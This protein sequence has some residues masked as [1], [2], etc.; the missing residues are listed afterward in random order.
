MKSKMKTILNILT[1]CA[2]LFML[3][4]CADGFNK[5][6]SEASNKPVI[7]FTDVVS[8]TIIP[9]EGNPA[10][11]TDYT[12]T[13]QIDEGAPV[14]P[15]GFSGLTHAQ[16]LGKTLELNQSDINKIITFNLSAT[17]NS[18][19]Y[20]AERS[21]IINGGENTI[22]LELYRYDLGNS[23]T[24][25]DISITVDFSG[26]PNA[27]TVTKV[28]LRLYDRYK[29]ELN[30]QIHQ[31]YAEQMCNVSNCTFTYEQEDVPV[32]SYML[33]VTFYADRVPVL[34][35]TPI[36][37]V[38]DG[39][40][41][42]A[43]EETEEFNIKG[44]NELYTITYNPNAGTDIVIYSASSKASR[45]LKEIT[46]SIPE[47]EGYL[48]TGWFLDS[49]C[50]KPLYLPV[51]K[52]TTVYAGWQSLNTTTE[53][54]YLASMEM[55]T[56]VV[57]GI[58]VTEHGFG[59]QEKPAVLKMLGAVNYSDIYT[60]ETVLKAKND[61][62]FE[63]DLSEV[64]DLTEYCP[65][66]EMPKLTGIK[67]PATVSTIYTSDFYRYP[68][69]RTIDVSEQNETFASENNVLYNKDKTELS[70]YPAGLTE[71]TFEIPEGVTAINNY[72]FFGQ[73]IQNIIIPSSVSVISNY[74]FYYTSG[75]TEFE[76]TEEN[77]NFK[78][79]NGIVYN[80]S[81]NEICAFTTASTSFTIPQGV[82]CIR[83]N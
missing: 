40:T 13:Y 77:E 39:L 78:S 1:F 14:E 34:V 35:M 5:K 80:K 2:A 22:A 49:D 68:K 72:S 26:K 51:Y 23:D 47:R 83:A 37:Q 48:F 76:V 65:S 8:R 60:I 29:N 4:S 10:D 18:L 59:T 64:I 70:L 19:R 71:D 6:A 56:T 31:A 82:R 3:F 61:I 62:W 43:T 7:R 36:I 41:T 55:L 52:D 81:G 58:T 15:E 75:I 11:F 44:F 53:G 74:A 21:V 45:L 73:N 27:Q 9:T 46:V 33:E 30:P 16:F 67:F 63:L 79:I 69:L 42:T 17:Y 25:G 38:A 20:Y 54:L 24:Y 28:G 57:N 66:I 50:T 12:L 32:G